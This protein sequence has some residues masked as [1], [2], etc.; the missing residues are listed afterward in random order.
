MR[1]YC[2]KSHPRLLPG[3]IGERL[4]P[5]GVDTERCL[6]KRH[7]R[8]HLCSDLGRVVGVAAVAL[9]HRFS[10]GELRL[11]REARGRGRLELDSRPAAVLRA[12]CPMHAIIA[13]V[14]GGEQHPAE[15]AGGVVGIG[16]ASVNERLN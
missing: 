16:L 12:K 15:L 10:G 7:G 3:A 11:G 1:V 6:D 4:H 13:G 2:K 5:V 8:L 14:A 9:V